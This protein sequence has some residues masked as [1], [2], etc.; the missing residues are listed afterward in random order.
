[1]VSGPGVQALAQ[2]LVQLMVRKRD[3]VL[4][5]VKY[6]A[7]NTQKKDGRRFEGR[8]WFIGESMELVIPIT[9]ILVCILH[10]SEALSWQKLKW[11]QKTTMNQEKGILFMERI[12]V[13]LTIIVCPD[14]VTFRSEEHTSE[15]Q[16]RGHL[17]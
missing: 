11:L 17:V 2:T 12:R 15:L 5:L 9:G 8:G 6:W 3:P 13:L 14:Y 7:G 1:M 4:V 16:S 10:V